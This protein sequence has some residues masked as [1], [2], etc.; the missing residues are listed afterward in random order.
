MIEVLENNFKGRGEVK[1]IFFMQVYSN[2]FAYIYRAVD[3]NTYYE[4]FERKN[5]PVCIDFEKRIYSESEF[6]ET[7]P[8]SNAFGVWAWTFPKFKD[9][10]NKFD[11]IE[12]KCK[13]NEKANN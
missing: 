7:Y 3:A 2:E 12:L 8:K 4:V 9:A 1:D 11:E 6:K 10:L 5:S 13:E